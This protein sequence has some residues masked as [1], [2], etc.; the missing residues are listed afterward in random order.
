[1]LRSQVP[2]GSPRQGFCRVVPSSD[3]RQKEVRRM[4]VRR[5][6]GR[7]RDLAGHSDGTAITLIPPAPAYWP[8]HA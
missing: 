6:A 5:S 4:S 8:S 2:R 1:M 3:A 7:M